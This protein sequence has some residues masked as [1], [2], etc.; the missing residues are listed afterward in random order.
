M[1]PKELITRIARALVDHPEEVSVNQVDSETTVIFEL[2]VSKGDI[3]RVIGKHGRTVYAMRTIIG[4]V[5]GK[6]RKRFMLEIVE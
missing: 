1:D 4:A 5:V 2:T 3:G 6:T